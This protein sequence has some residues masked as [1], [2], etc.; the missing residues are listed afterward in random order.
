MDRILEQT[1]TALNKLGKRVDAKREENRFRVNTLDDL[2]HL[3]PEQPGCY[4]IESTMPLSK[5]RKSKVRKTAPP[6]GAQLIKK[7]K[8]QLFIVYV[9][10]ESNVRKRLKEHLLAT[11]TIRQK[12]LALR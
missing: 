6:N 5:F 9:G 4:W 2:D 7:K 1:V 3:V 12:S 8:G 11:A 10:T